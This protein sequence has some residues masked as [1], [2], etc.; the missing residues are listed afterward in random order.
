MRVLDTA[1]TGLIP[2]CEVPHRL[3]T[4]QR[5]I[6]G[7]TPSIFLRIPKNTPLLG[8]GSRGDSRIWRWCEGSLDMRSGS[9]QKGSPAVKLRHMRHNFPWKKKVGTKLKAEEEQMRC[10]KKESSTWANYWCT[11][12]MQSSFHISAE[13]FSK[14][15]TGREKKKKKRMWGYSSDELLLKM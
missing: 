1:R 8:S 9:S 2:S 7:S 14:K 6:P 10:R 3:G 13:L 11:K 4:G 15:I 5:V 12:I